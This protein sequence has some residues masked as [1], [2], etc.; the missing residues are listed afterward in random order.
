MA[1]HRPEDLLPRDGHIVAHIRR[2]RWAAHNSRGSDPPAVRRRQRPARAPSSMP[3]WMRPASILL[4]CASTP[5]SRSTHG[6]HRRVPDRRPSRSRPPPWSSDGHLVLLLA[7]DEQARRRVARLARIGE[8][9]CRRSDCTA[10][11]RSAPSRTILADLPPSS[12]GH[13]LDRVGGGFGHQDAG[14]GGTGEGHHVDVG[15]LGNAL[16]HRG[17][18]AVHKIEDTGRDARLVHHL[19]KQNVR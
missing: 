18:I 8:S 4:N 9:G 6:C 16:A 13:A 10:L 1:A 3:F 5:L 7:R 15:M 19:R 12:F 17:T 2:T 11:P 14:P